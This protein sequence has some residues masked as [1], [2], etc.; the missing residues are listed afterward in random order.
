M[1]AAYKNIFSRC[2]LPVIIIE[3]DSARIGGK[4]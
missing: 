2:G 3:A 1:I 4:D